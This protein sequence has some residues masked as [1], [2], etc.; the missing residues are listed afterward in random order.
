MI[1]R[2]RK[3]SNISLLVLYLIW[4]VNLPNI[5][6]IRKHMMPHWVFLKE[7][8]IASKHINSIL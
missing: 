7:H 1:E 3:L 2:Y 6:E 8:L 5:C 4:V